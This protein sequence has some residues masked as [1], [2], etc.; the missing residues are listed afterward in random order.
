MKPKEII[1]I[2]CFVVIIISSIHLCCGFNVDNEVAGEVKRPHKFILM[3]Y[4]IFEDGI[5]GG[6]LFLLGTDRLQ[7][8]Q[9]IQ[10]RVKRDAE[11]R[12]GINPIKM[13]N[14]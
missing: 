12:I 11:R 13:L 5:R 1:Y 2:S 14:L 9:N 7:P 6:P 8:P 10:H 4:P 3:P